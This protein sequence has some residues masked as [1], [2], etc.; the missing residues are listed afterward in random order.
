MF[1]EEVIK[2]VVAD[3]FVRQGKSCDNASKDNF[4]VL[5]TYGKHIQPIFPQLVSF[6][7]FQS[8]SIN[9]DSR[10]ALLYAVAG[11]ISHAHIYLGCLLQT[12]SPFKSLLRLVIS[13]FS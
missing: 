12:N 9:E 6:V 3:H 8:V 5:M 7:V 13:M 2:S 1:A 10:D 4:R 11:R